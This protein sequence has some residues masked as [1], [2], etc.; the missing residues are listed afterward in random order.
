MEDWLNSAYT[1]G[2]KYFVSNP[3]PA[4]GEE[5][6]IFF[7]ILENAPVTN[8]FLR[9]KQ[10]GVEVLNEME[11]AYVKNGLQYYKKSI[12]PYEDVLQYQIYIATADCVYYLTQSGI[13]PYMP[14]EA[15][16]FRIL[17]DYQQPSWVKGAVFYQIFPD[18]F[19]NG[20]PDNDVQNGEY[21]FDGHPTQRVENWDSTP[22]H[23]EKSFCLDF[24]GGD[25]E[26]ILAKIPYLKRLGVTALYLNP[27][28]FAATVHKYDCLDYFAVDPH[29]GGDEALSAL[30]TA[31][32]KEDMKL[33]LDVSINHTGIAHRWFNRDATFFPKT[34]GAYNN[35][36][37]PEREYYFFDE[38]NNYKAWFD[39]E[40]LP[41]L[42]YISQALRKQLYLAP[43]SLVKKWLKPPFSIDGWRFDVADTMARN[44]EIQLHHEIWPQL[45][46]SI[47]EE[48]P[49]AY[50][51]AED[52][53]D[54]EEFLRGDE[55]D[56]PMNYFG[57]A[58]PLR[59]FAG[60]ADLFNARNPLLRDKAYKPTAKHVAARIRSHL[61]KLPTV[62]QQNQFNLLDSHD[63]SR[64]HNNKKIHPGHVRGAVIMMFCLPGAP[65]IYY[66]D[67]ADIDGTT[68][69]VEGCRYPMPWSRDF[70]SEEKFALYSTLCKLKTGKDA[71]GDGGFKILHEEDYVFSFAR[72]TPHSL[73]VAV[74]STDDQARELRI[75]LGDFGLQDSAGRE[76]FDKA[77]C[78]ID[79]TDAVI[80]VKPHESYLFEF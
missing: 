79:G 75:P 17:T 23:Y 37:A 29:F 68:D 51:L 2:T 38:K 56:S 63:V 67:E 30:M 34:E 57:C 16:D 62:I 36:K 66:G 11:K 25:L 10:N 45:R 58:R 41:T 13:T 1:D 46:K 47:K 26:G 55:W 28:F 22:E 49:E 20:N 42:N 9:A 73:L 72:F 18:R 4:K 54:C 50:I 35:P 48:N 32:H 27:I 69:T 39:V 5:I 7:R 65:N 76:I 31:L 14:N 3:L 19:F 64:L 78:K 44:N 33:I 8:V 21:T 71:L 15:Y 59:E 60:E 61:C 43:D 24:Y 74:F 70:E 53:T 80:T 52:W 12:T 6:E 77:Q 40:T